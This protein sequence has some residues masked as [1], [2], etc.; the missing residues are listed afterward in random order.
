VKI[1]ISILAAIQ[2]SACTLLEPP[3]KFADS[4]VVA[5]AREELFEALVDLVDCASEFAGTHAD[6]KLTATEL[7]TTAVQ[8]CD[9]ERFALRD[10]GLSIA[11]LGYPGGAD[12]RLCYT[13]A[14]CMAKASDANRVALA[15][16]RS[17][18]MELIAR[19]TTPQ[20]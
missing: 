2:C 8:S 1:G 12:H 7:S 5:E 9:E 17:K 18:V 11:L 19:K 13:D 4:G 20:Q 3:P 6:S 15:T 16:A 14:E 10:T